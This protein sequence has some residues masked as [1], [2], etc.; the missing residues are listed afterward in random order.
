MMTREQRQQAVALIQQAL[1]ELEWTY[2]RR[3]SNVFPAIFTGSARCSTSSWRENRRT[4]WSVRGTKKS[5]GSWLPPACSS[6]C[7]LPCAAATG[8]YGQLVPLE[9]GVLV[10]MTALKRICEL[11]TAR[12][13]PRPA[14]ARQR[15]KTPP[16]RRDGSCVACRR[17]SVWPA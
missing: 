13:A 16:V 12:C 15:L 1:P 4:R 6:S 7:R 10:D 2:S 14:F 5:Y 8:N 17:P 11:K 3:R 9:G